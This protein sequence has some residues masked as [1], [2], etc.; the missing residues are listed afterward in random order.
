M[1]FAAHIEIELEFGSSQSG[2]GIRIE[3]EVGFDS[4]FAIELE[5]ELDMECGVRRDLALTL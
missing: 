3:F 1:S 2:V 5:F 4:G